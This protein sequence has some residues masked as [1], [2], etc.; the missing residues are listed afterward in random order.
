MSS[1]IQVGAKVFF[2]LWPIATLVRLLLIPICSKICQTFVNYDKRFDFWALKVDLWQMQSH[3]D[4][5]ELHFWSIPRLLVQ[6]EC[7]FGY[8]FVRFVTFLITT[9]LAFFHS[10]CNWNWFRE[11]ISSPI[12]INSD[13]LSNFRQYPGEN[14][15]EQDSIS[16]S[17][18]N[19]F[20]SWC[21]FS[22]GREMFAEEEWLWLEIPIKVLRSLVCSE[23]Y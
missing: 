6:F 12:F 19:C 13:I 22:S 5:F 3:F 4:P 2:L 20:E 23:P 10:F 1:R 17:T 7:S 15:P 18:R 14:A 16:C 8:F 9:I 11:S 21:Q